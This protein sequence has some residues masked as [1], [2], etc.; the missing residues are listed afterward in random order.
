MKSSQHKIYLMK[1]YEKF[2]KNSSTS[3]L[4]KSIRDNDNIC[5]LKPE[6]RQYVNNNITQDKPETSTKSLLV[7]VT[8]IC[9]W[10][11]AMC[12]LAQVTYPFLQA[13]CINSVQKLN[14]SKQ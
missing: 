6:F 13:I 1:N 7:F 5:L 10:C 14:L 12:L 11:F 8:V 4:T 9:I 3:K 2:R